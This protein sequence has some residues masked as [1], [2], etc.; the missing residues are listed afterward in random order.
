MIGNPAQDLGLTRRDRRNLK[1]LKLY[2]A[3]WLVSFLFVHLTR[4][5][6]TL[7]T[8]PVWAWSAI[9]VAVISGVLL[10]HAYFR[11]IQGSDELMRKIHVEALAFGFGMAFVFGMGADLLGQVGLD[12]AAEGTWAVMIVAYAV[13]LRISRKAYSE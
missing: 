3:I 7:E 2:G 8:Q 12:D 10:A 9:A 11:F 13:K 6:G 1:P 4:G 5:E